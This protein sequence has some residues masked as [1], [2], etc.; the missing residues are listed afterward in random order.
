MGISQHRGFF[1]QRC[2]KARPSWGLLMGFCGYFCGT[3]TSSRLKR[4]GRPLVNQRITSYFQKTFGSMKPCRK[5]RWSDSACNP[6]RKISETTKYQRDN[7]AVETKFPPASTDCVIFENPGAS[8]ALSCFSDS[9]ISCFSS[10]ASKVLGARSPPGWR[11][12]WNMGHKR[13]YPS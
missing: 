4:I 8:D 11:P 2:P 6:S 10:R 3:R 9:L 5:C 1:P 13:E 12:L 7:L